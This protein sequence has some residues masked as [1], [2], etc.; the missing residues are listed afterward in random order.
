[1]HPVLGEAPVRTRRMSLPSSGI[2]PS[3]VRPTPVQRRRRGR[4]RDRAELELNSSDVNISRVLRIRSTSSARPETSRSGQWPA[5]SRSGSR[6]RPRSRRAR[7][8]AASVRTAWPA[9]LAAMVVRSSSRSPSPARDSSSCRSAGARGGPSD[10]RRAD[11]RGAVGGRRAARDQVEPGHPAGARLR[12]R[13]GARGRFEQAARGSSRSRARSPATPAPGRCCARVAKRYDSDLAATACARVARSRS[14]AP[15]RLLEP[16]QRPLDDVVAGRGG[17]RRRRDHQRRVERDPGER[18]PQPRVQEREHERLVVEEDPVGDEARATPARGWRAAS[19]AASGGRR[20][21]PSARRGRTRCPRRGRA[22][23][24]GSR[25]R[26]WRERV[27]RRGR[28]P[29]RRASG[30][31]NATPQHASGCSVQKRTGR[32]RVVA[33][34]RS[35]ALVTARTRPPA[36]HVHVPGSWLPNTDVGQIAFT[37]ARDGDRGDRARHAA[38][39]LQPRLPVAVATAQQP[40]HERG[41]ERQQHVERRLDA[42][43]SRPRR[44]RR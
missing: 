10:G 6:P 39:Q 23:P 37:A 41:V 27:A 36:N 44:S 30:S 7:A 40:R 34:A 5:K 21:R 43:G 26:V 20:G 18:R 9:I 11:R 2:S 24:A 8:P 14:A 33:A 4:R 15:A 25:R 31:A 3:S 38:D 35:Q 17:R 12:D 28:R 29:R 19:R 16:Q 42:A 22:G 1:M 32:G 13:R